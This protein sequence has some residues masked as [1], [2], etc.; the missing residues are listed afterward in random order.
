MRKFID[1]QTWHH[2]YIIDQQVETSS[3]NEKT[4]D[5][6]RLLFLQTIN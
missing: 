5:S 2:E 6:V 3:T 1:E 4:R